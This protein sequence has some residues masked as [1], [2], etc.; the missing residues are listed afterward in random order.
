[1]VF[2]DPKEVE[3]TNIS[4]WA[5]ERLFGATSIGTTR[6]LA[7]HIL[8]SFNLPNFQGLYSFSCFAKHNIGDNL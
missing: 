1:M 4:F 3:Q 8:V 5:P 6:P 2:Q 7:A